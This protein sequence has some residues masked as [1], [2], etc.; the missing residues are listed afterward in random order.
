MIHEAVVVSRG[1]DG[2]PHITPLGY[3]CEDEHIVLSPFVPSTTLANLERDR[4][5]TLCLTD[6]VR[7][8]A[9]CL[10]GRRD[11]ALVAT[12]VIAG[13][14]LAD[15]LA[16]MELQVAR[17]EADPVRP[18]FFCRVA[19]QVTH[20]AFRGFNRAQAAVVEGAILVSRLERLPQEKIDAEMAYLEIAIEKTAGERERQAWNWLCDAVAAHRSRSSAEARP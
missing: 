15:T 9:G 18:R 19:N 11:H 3:R 8:I 13:W 17:I 6:D 20:A 2:A 12:D 10:T 1:A 5:A 14:R 4:H 7:V 16:H